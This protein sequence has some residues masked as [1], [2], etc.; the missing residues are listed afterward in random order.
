MYGWLNSNCHRYLILGTA[1]FVPRVFFIF[2]CFL[3]SLFAV[4]DGP[5]VFHEKSSTRVV[6]IKKD[7]VIEKKFDK[8]L[9]KFKGFAGDSRSYS[10]ELPSSFVSHYDNVSR[11][12][13]ISDI[14]GQHEVFLNLLR[15][16]EVINKRNRWSFGKGHL[17]ITGDV[18]DRG[19]AV[20]ESVWFILHLARQAR[21]DG[22]RVH[23]L[24]GNHETMVLRGDDRYL[25]RKYH[26]VA[27]LLKMPM[28]QIYGPASFL[29]QA[30]RRQNAL[31]RINDTL[32]LHGGIHPQLAEERMS[33]FTINHLVRN[34]IDTAR[35]QQRIDF[36]F[37]SSGVFWYR[38]F[39][40]QRR[41]YEKITSAQVKD[42]LAHFKVK[43]ICV[44]HTTKK[45]IKSY[46][47][48]RIVAID[49]G[50][51]YGIKEKG[52]GLLF[53]HGSFRRVTSDGSLLPIRD[54][55]Y[56][57]QIKERSWE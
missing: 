50:I 41:K 39:F 22:G 2:F 3:V 49:A 38:G 21:R 25:H 55:P 45:Q 34:N 8:K 23:Y 20:T 44:G 24:L 18:F 43:R 47:D 53:Q 4:D 35:G 51:K 36:L 5:Y 16:A 56:Q 17:V 57:Q 6:Y 27:R 7:K 46:F 40:R 32:F 10:L 28:A 31:V 42:V 1:T 14:H 13:A 33:L 19:P 15:Q 26:R 9:R 52:E 11:W 54:L 29:G 30:L 48:G 12:F 37:G